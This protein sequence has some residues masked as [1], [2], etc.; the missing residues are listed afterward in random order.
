MMAVVMGII[1][2]I[3]VAAIIVG[4]EHRAGKKRLAEGLYEL[5]GVEYMSPETFLYALREKRES[6]NR[7]REHR[8]RRSKRKA[9]RR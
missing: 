5:D 9:L 3:L 4:V 2:A 1:L 8:L 6:W 7:K